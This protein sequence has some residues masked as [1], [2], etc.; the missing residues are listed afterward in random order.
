MS[1]IN[2]RLGGD[3]SEFR[4]MMRNA[5]DEAAKHAG[6]ITKK[7]GDKFAGLNDVA[8]TL[9]TAL[10]LN[11]QNIANKTA[12]LFTGM[13]EEQVKSLERIGQLQ[14]Q[15][16]D[17]AIAAARE[18][19]SVE[20]KLTLA[21]QDREKAEAQVGDAVERGNAAL[22]QTPS[23][24]TAITNPAMAVYQLY[25]RRHEVT[26]AT[27]EQERALGEQVKATQSVTQLTKEQKEQQKQIS[28]QL[29]QIARNEAEM[30]AKGLGYVEQRAL[31]EQKILAAEQ[32]IAKEVAGSIEYNRAV[33]K[34]QNER[35]AAAALDLKHEQDGRLD[36]NKQL[37][38]ALLLAK[39]KQPITESEKIYIKEMVA[40][41]ARQVKESANLTSEDRARLQVS[42]LQTKQKENQ[43]DIGEMLVKG[44]ENLTDKEL[45]QLAF[46][47]AVN[48]EIDRQIKIR[49]VAL[50][51]ADQAVS[52]AERQLATEQAIT[53]EINRRNAEQNA[54]SS[55]G[56]RF[57]F[58]Q[59]PLNH[60]D[61]SGV[62]DAALEEMIRRSRSEASRYQV[63]SPDFDARNLLNAGAVASGFLGAGFAESSL[64]TVANSAQAE[65]DLRRGIRTGAINVKNFQGDPLFFD[66]LV[67]D[68]SSSNPVGNEI[69]NQLTKLNQTIGSIRAGFNKVVTMPP[70]VGGNG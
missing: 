69:K 18:R 9:S 36:I 64:N 50:G 3:N 31:A 24:I 16:A 2:V 52:T 11:L 32:A 1:D 66:K 56:G 37:E 67:Q 58:V 61:F 7:V 55:P 47:N 59:R 12:E 10:G 70:V 8:R 53:E 30:A 54:T 38:Q 27:V 6:D 29:V 25:L 48:V 45:R 44:V 60:E 19:L 13:S 21:I 65:L 51:V 17:M 26:K 43:R 4:T 42:A 20:G 15:L 34:L 35:A 49:T 40:D 41:V 28:E 57:A 39:A 62:S 14:T 68:V 5:A 23:L 63:G 33:L 46:I 22:Q